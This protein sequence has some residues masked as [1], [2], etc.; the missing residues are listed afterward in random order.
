MVCAKNNIIVSYADDATPLAGTPSPIMKSDVNESLK[1]RLK[2]S[3]WCIYG[4]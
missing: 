4:A 3:A 2:I 1:K